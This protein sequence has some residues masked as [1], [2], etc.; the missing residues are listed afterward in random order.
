[1]NQEKN[2]E[3]D[4]MLRKLGRPS[5]SA[6]DRTSSDFSDDQH[7]DADELNMYAENV[8]APTTRARYTEHLADCSQ[9][10]KTVS[11]LT[12]A[13]GG[14]LHEKKV[15]V[16]ASSWIQG[17]MSRLFS[18]MVLRYA[19]P[20]LVL[21]IITSIGFWVFTDSWSRQSGTANEA[22]QSVAK[23]EPAP[24]VSNATQDKTTEANASNSKPAKENVETRQRTE[25][26]QPTATPGDAPKG[27]APKEAEERK[28]DNPAKPVDEIAAT[29]TSVAGAAPASPRQV[30]SEEKVVVDDAAKKN[31]AAEPSQPAR[32]GGDYQKAPEAKSE[33]RGM[34]GAARSKAIKNE[35]TESVRVQQQR[36]SDE[37]GRRADKDDAETRSVAGRQFRKE[38]SVWIDTAYSSQAT[39]N[40]SRGS[41][42][43]RAL[44]ADEPSIR[45]IAD[46]L[47]VEV[48]V[49]WK[50][51]AYRLR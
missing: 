38:G 26:Q 33:V 43:Y 39:T 47:G 31:K 30:V 24:N 14:V 27:D 21:V 37:R 17:L 9:C 42:Q 5:D 29:S 48:I 41:E 40:V 49:V 34:A 23:N 36:E 10:R 45:T 8:L 1:M 6:A 22:A 50:G 20:A 51:R 11:Q 25:E 13:A 2:N 12:L 35:T 44:I 32:A 46:Q 15:T 3:I 16:P 28:R 19:A 4:L 18:P 7:L